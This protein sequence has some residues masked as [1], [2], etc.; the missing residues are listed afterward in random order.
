MISANPWQSFILAAS[1]ITV[2]YYA[3][4][5][6]KYYLSDVKLLLSKKSL[7]GPGHSSHQL[8]APVKPGSPDRPI[9]EQEEEVPPRQNEAF[10]ENAQDLLAH[11]TD[12]IREAYQKNYTKQDLVQMLQM[13][14]KEYPAQKGSSF[15]LA[16]N[17]R[18][19]AECAK[20]G[21][22]YLS[23]GDKKQVWTTV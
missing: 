2:I 19:D 18:I 10:L 8:D 9:D 3:V 20:Y 6:W 4:I 12:E 13:I 11:L 17:D 1:I 7:R 21:S 22:I 14:L 16:V 15:Q 23:E 5:V